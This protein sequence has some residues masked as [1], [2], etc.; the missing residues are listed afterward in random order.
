MQKMKVL[1]KAIVQKIFFYFGIRLT[2]IPR[3][4]DPVAPF[5]A[6]E[7]AVQFQLIKEKET[8]YF[9]QIGANDGVLADSLNPLIR[10]YGLHGCLVEPMK[11]VFRDLKNNYSDQPQLDFRAVMI[12]SSDDTGEIYR[13]KR[14][15]PVP[16]NFF[17]GLARAD[18]N[19]IQKRAEAVGL[20]DMYERLECVMQT[21][22]TFMLTLPVRKISMLYIDTEGS[23]DQIIEAAFESGIFP[24]II[25]YEWSEMSTERRFL[26]KMKLLDNGYRFIDIGADTVCIR[27]EIE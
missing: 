5:D 13:F 3:F 19:Y 15:A 9:V 8:F 1:V 6:L 14:D 24:A 16:A 26:L 7:L 10:K 2:R 17:H 27:G 21:F 4:V 18:K 23:G 25:N 11:D 22:S 12:G 20:P